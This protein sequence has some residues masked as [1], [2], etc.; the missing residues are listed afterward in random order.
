MNLSG[1]TRR[2]GV[3]CIATLALA[4]ATSSFAGTVSVDLS[5]TIEQVVSGPVTPGEPFELRWVIA[6]NANNVSSLALGR[7]NFDTG[8]EF[9]EASCPSK[10]VAGVLVWTPPS[11]DSAAPRQ[12]VVNV[13]SLDV[14]VLQFNARVETSNGDIDFDESNNADV[15]LVDVEAGTNAVDLAVSLAQVANGPVVAGTPFELRW[16][17]ANELPGSVSSVATAELLLSEQIEFVGTSCP[18]TFDA[19]VVTWAP[20][21]VDNAA[22]RQCVVTLRSGDPGEFTLETD[23]QASAQ[24]S[25]NNLANNSASLLVTILGGAVAVRELPTLG[26]P[27]GLALM[28]GLVACAAMVK[29]KSAAAPRDSGLS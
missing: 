16:T 25:D 21:S 10:F 26:W 6:N 15:L 28:G 19:G 5:T 17:I 4:H 18:S 27:A 7:L 1:L 13:R 12:C 22:P 23:V 3:T 20:P 11:V 8:A 9:I 24:D 14:D 29:R 2:V